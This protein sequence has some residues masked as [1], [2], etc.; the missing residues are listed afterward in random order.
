[1]NLIELISQAQEEAIARGI[2]A[3]TII[4]NKHLGYIKP[5]CFGNYHS[6]SVGIF[7]PMIMG[8]EIKSATLPEETDFLICQRKMTDREEIITS[9]QR[10]AL[11]EF[12]E[13]LSDYARQVKENGYDGIGEN[14][15]QEKLKE[16]LER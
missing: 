5:F 11:T 15:I 16:F 1:M 4:I 12:A 8:M 13:Y 3:N 9:A 7:P 10:Q 6:L 2:K 14:D